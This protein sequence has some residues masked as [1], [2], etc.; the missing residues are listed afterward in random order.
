MRCA[1]GADPRRARRGI[2]KL[3]FH[4]RA[5]ARKARKGR[6][7]VGFCVREGELGWAVES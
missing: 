1:R 3:R 5:Q 4:P 7:W 2:A 6:F